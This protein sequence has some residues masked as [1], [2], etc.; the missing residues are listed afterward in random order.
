MQWVKRAEMSQLTTVESWLFET[1]VS[2]T[3]QSAKKQTDRKKKKI[4]IT[5]LINSITDLSALT[6]KHPKRKR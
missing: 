3:T 1:V 4:N 6:V 2:K 5:K